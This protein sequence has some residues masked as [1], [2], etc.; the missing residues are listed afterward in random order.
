MLRATR[1]PRRVQ[2]IVRE[3]RED[4]ESM[5]IGETTNYPRDLR[6]R[7]VE[8][9]GKKVSPFYGGNNISS[10]ET[11]TLPLSRLPFSLARTCLL[12]KWFFKKAERDHCDLILG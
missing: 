3:R 9:Q 2:I 6:G 4:W 10:S 12:A 11:L 7:R 1:D 8:W 5:A